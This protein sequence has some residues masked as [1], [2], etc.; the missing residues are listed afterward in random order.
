MTMSD[1]L[2]QT[3]QNMYA[4]F[5][6]GD[7]AGLFEYLADDIQW[8]YNAKKSD[9]PWQA[10]VKGKAEVPQI[11]MALAEG[12]EIEKY[13]ILEFIHSGSRVVVRVD[14]AFKV[15]KT[16]KRVHTEQIHLW[17]FNAQGKA[18]FLRHYEDTAQTVAAYHA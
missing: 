5:G 7:V 15:K 1:Q 9:V 17:G 16:G 13:D 12:I 4:A 3:T 6:R 11:L 2:L 14:F 8:D 10:A 18:N